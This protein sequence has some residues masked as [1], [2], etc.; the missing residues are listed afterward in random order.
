MSQGNPTQPPLDLRLL[1]HSSSIQHHSL[2]ANGHQHSKEK[3]MTLGDDNSRPLGNKVGKKDDSLP[4]WSL[5]NVKRNKEKEANKGIKIPDWSPEEERRFR[6]DT[7]SKDTPSLRRCLAV[8]SLTYD[9]SSC[10]KKR[11]NKRCN[12]QD[13]A[14]ECASTAS[15]IGVADI[16]IAEKKSSPLIKSS[17]V[18]NRK[19]KSCSASREEEVK[20]VDHEVQVDA[21]SVFA[22]ATLKDV[23]KSDT[24]KRKQSNDNI[25]SNI[26]SNN[27]HHAFR[28]YDVNTSQKVMQYSE[29]DTSST[30]T[31]SSIQEDNNTYKVIAIILFKQS[32]FNTNFNSL[33]N[34]CLLNVT[35]INY[36]IYCILSLLTINSF[37]LQLVSTKIIFLR[38]ILV[39]VIS[40]TNLYLISQH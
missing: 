24:S 15:D 34:I 7:E 4:D 2:Q 35:P 3:L 6:I 10:S 27:N 19:G 39:I 28:K 21:S 18:T 30:T 33:Y 26:G 8:A 37:I 17:P 13:I 23:V 36:T 22:S 40:L 12:A 5:M 32:N 38:S 9:N 31:E 1:S 11:S 29:E 16:Q 20:F 25:A 14:A